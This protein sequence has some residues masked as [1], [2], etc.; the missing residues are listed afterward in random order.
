M[1]KIR[2]QR[3]RRIGEKYFLLLPKE[4]VERLGIDEDTKLEVV[5][6]RYKGRVWNSCE[7]RWIQ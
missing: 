3:P 1:I 5:I 6:D 2:P 4:I 7:S